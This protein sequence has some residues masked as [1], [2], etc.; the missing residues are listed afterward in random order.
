MGYTAAPCFFLHIVMAIIIA[1]HAP[2]AFAQTSINASGAGGGAI[3]PGADSRACDTTTEGSL[4]WNSATSCTEYCNGYG[5]TCPPTTNCASPV[6]AFQIVTLPTAGSGDYGWSRH[7]GISY[8][9]S[10]AVI[11]AGREGAGGNLLVTSD[12]GETWTARDSLR[13]WNALSASQNGMVMAATTYGG[14]IYVSTNG[15]TNWTAYGPSANWIDIEMSADGTQM[16]AAVENG[17]L[18]RSTNTGATWAALTH[19][20]VNTDRNWFAV[21]SSANGQRLLASENGGGYLYRSADGGTTWTQGTDLGDWRTVDMTPDASVMIAGIGYGSIYRSTDYGATWTVGNGVQDGYPW[22]TY[23]DHHN[24][25]DDGTL[26]VS[27]SGI[28]A[29]STD[30]GNY[31]Y[32]LPYTPTWQYSSAISGNGQRIVSFEYWDGDTIYVGRKVC[33]QP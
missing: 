19:A 26:T 3:I 30:Q 22:A 6:W 21:S 15:G 17:R 7:I 13:F 32:L 25:T 24:I 27:V 4:R 8:D 5:W 33:V 18:Y 9:G 20:T 23:S 28:V 16:I 10:R 11:A 29:T 1:G 31:Q 14:Q 12:Y 2:S